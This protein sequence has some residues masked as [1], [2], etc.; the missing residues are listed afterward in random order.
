ME[1]SYSGK[2]FQTWQDLV[3]TGQALT[4]LLSPIDLFTIGHSHK[5]T[6]SRKTISVLT[7]H[8]SPFTFAFEISPPAIIA[9]NV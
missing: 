8:L 3:M 6:R 7:F 5:T 4:G 9:G 2:T 1:R